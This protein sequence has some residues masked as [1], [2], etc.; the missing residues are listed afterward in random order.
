MTLSSKVESSAPFFIPDWPCPP[1]VRALIS[2]RQGGVSEGPYASLNLGAHVGDDPSAVAENRAR[3]TANL[4]AEPLWLEQV[5]GIEVI[6][7]AHALASNLPPRA[8]AAWARQSGVVCTVMT[9]D[10][11]PL[12][13]CDRS[14]SV[15][16]AAHA[17]WRGLCAGVIEATVRAMKVPG[18]DLLA[19]LGPAIGPAAFE[20]G[21]EVR[22]AF[23]AQAPEAAHCFKHARDA[24]TGK[25]LADIYELARLRLRALGVADMYGGTACTYGDAGRFHS[26]RRDGA[27][28]GRMA[29]MIWLAA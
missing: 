24:Q 26:Y 9:A 29:S 20:V 4:P 8:D 2:T 15:V 10:C 18:A 16:A 22:S 5:H 17:G 21:D 14:G 7:A 19:Y 27:R 11:L 6:D 13:L 28:S 23:V 1:G 12:L 25:W 3:L